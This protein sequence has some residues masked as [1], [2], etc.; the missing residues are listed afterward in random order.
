MAT[1]E[2]LSA[3][4]IKADAAGNTA[5]AKAL[6]DEIRRMRTAP[7]EF[8]IQ[9]PEGRNV[10]VDVQFPSAP[11]PAPTNEI[12]TRR[13]VAEFLAPTVEAL[14]TAGG[15]VLGTAAGPLGT[16]AGAGAGFAGAK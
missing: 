4:L 14:G 11:A 8:T 10:G 3:A 12:P 7:Q 2:Q 9:T 16:L 15:A 6:A 5:D 1:I 13:K